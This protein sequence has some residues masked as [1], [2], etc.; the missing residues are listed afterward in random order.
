MFVTGR[1]TN[2]DH[3]INLKVSLKLAVI[4]KFINIRCESLK[5]HSRN[6]F[7]KSTCDFFSFSFRLL[8]FNFITPELPS[9][10]VLLDAILH[11]TLQRQAQN[12][13]KDSAHIRNKLYEI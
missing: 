12:G 4:D 9:Y 1:K 13:I 10:T 6:R 8:G 3:S 11:F 7:L 5:V 2:N